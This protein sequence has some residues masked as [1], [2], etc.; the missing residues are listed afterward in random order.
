MDDTSSENALNVLDKE[1]RST[2]DAQIHDQQIFQPDFAQS[3]KKL[4]VR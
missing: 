3:D 2:L 4:K 1:Y